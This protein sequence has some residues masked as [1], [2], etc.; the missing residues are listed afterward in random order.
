M[1]CRLHTGGVEES[2]K[3]LPVIQA[4]HEVAEPQPREHVADGRTQLHF[5]HW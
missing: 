1:Q 4:D 2:R 5:D 3:H